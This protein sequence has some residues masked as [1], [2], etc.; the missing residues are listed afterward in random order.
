[1]RYR[2]FL[3]FLEGVKAP[4]PNAGNVRS[5]SID[6]LRRLNLPERKGY[7]FIMG[8]KGLLYE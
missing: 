1:M 6:Q 2:G 8:L 4:P 7:A 5:V 3:K